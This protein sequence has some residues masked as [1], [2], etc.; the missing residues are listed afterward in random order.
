MDCGTRAQKV[1]YGMS[2]KG[3][4]PCCQSVT[5]TAEL[6]LPCTLA[7]IKADR[8][9]NSSYVK[10][11]IGQRLMPLPIWKFLLQGNTWFLETPHVDIPPPLP[12]TWGNIMS[13]EILGQATLPRTNRI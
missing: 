12:V 5:E 11:I 2:S 10:N 1:F 7:P 4:Y 8:K 6:A 9:Q 13:L 3:T